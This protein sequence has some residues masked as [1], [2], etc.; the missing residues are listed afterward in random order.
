M[1]A[2]CRIRMTRRDMTNDC[3]R[4]RVTEVLSRN[5][6]RAKKTQECTHTREE[7]VDEVG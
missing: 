1:T 7:R 6:V 5:V 4:T 2:P 3:A